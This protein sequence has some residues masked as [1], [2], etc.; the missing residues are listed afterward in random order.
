MPLRLLTRSGLLV[1]ALC[2]CQE[3]QV[4][5]SIDPSARMSLESLT[6]AIQIAVVAGAVQE[7]VELRAGILKPLWEPISAPTESYASIPDGATMLPDRPDV[8]YR[9]PYVFSPTKQYVAAAVLER[10]SSSLFA[11]D[12]SIV[13]AINKKVLATIKGDSNEA[14]DALAWSPNSEAIAILKTIE[15]PAAFSVKT[16]IASISGQS[17][18]SETYILE[19][20]G[21]DGRRWVR[22]KL[23]EQVPQG[24][25]E[26]MWV[27]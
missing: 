24:T 22:T 16:L 12:F 23:L 2:G 27:K 10:S 20:Y 9:G 6:G 18:R 1:L 21:S 19:V 4:A 8:E 13:D 25:G 26:I 17:A 3:Q 7:K 11:S 5:I 15:Y 14:I